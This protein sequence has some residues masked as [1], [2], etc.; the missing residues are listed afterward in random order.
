MSFL[1][2]MIRAAMRRG[3]FDDLPGT[4]KPLDLD[5]DRHTPEHLRLAHKILKDNDL[6]PDWIL[7]AREVDAARAGW[8][9]SLRKAWHAGRW[10]ILRETL[11]D[12]ARQINRRILSFNLKAPRGVPHRAMIDVRYEVDRLRAGE[13]SR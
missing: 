7:E 10:P 4:G 6:A 12:S 5:D 9:D 8:I 13:P 1:D 3:E 2:D 11:E